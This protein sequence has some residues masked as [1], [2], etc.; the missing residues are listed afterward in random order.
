VPEAVGKRDVLSERVLLDLARAGDS[1]A[2]TTIIKQ[3]NQRLYRL[4]RSILRDDAEA[5]D[6]LQDAYCSAFANLDAFR[7]DAQ[8]GTWLGR[9]VINEALARLRRR[10]PTVDLSEINESAEAAQIIPFPGREA[11]VDPETRA[12]QREIYVLLERAIDNLPEVFRT[13]LFARVIEG[14]SVEEAAELF[15]IPP[16]TI[17]TRLHRARLLLKHQLEKSIGAVLSDA[18]PFAG[19]RCERLTE[20]VLKKLALS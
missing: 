10:R 19:R 8:L 6:S 7:G 11:M 12:A 16:E 15:D 17:K 4:A 14:M 13:V 5:E 18:F 1:D 2:I 20:R 9:I 3:H